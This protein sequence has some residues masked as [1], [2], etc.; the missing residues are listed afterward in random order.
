MGFK[1]NDI[2]FMQYLIFFLIEIIFLYFLSKNFSRRL[3]RSLYY[4][5]KSKKKAIYFYSIVCLPGIFIHE[6]AHFLMAL[7]LFV[8]VGKIDFLPDI[9]KSGGSLGSVKIGKTDF[10]RS[11]LIAVAPLIFGLG[12]IF[13][14][15]SFVAGISLLDNWLVDIL[16][17]YIVF[18]TANNMFIS[19][20]DAKVA[21]RLIIF[22]FVLAVIVGIFMGQ[23]SLNYK[24]IMPEKLI[25][26]FK[27]VDYYL[28]A[29]ILIDTG[30]IS[31]FKLLK[32]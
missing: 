17:I 19:K 20:E 30:L 1:P 13:A 24:V 27:R 14:A 18:E 31:L 23:L 32:F 26:I 10:V 3:I 11:F 28:L 8:P 12:I 9:R 4:L 15:I 29:P 22:L 7:L 2:Y 25:W 16:I 21:L 6:V 5:T